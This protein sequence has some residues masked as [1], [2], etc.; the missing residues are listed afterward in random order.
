MKKLLT[1]VA[2]LSVTTI[3]WAGSDREATVNRMD[4]A[5]AV[6]QEVMSAPD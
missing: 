2:V 1:F 5:G 3:G 4:H 6:L